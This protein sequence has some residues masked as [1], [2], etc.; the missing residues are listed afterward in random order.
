MK[1]EHNMHVNDNYETTSHS[2]GF[3]LGLL[4]GAAVGAA[5][6]LLLAPKTGAEM[7]RTLADSA[8][9]FRRKAGETY[10]Q[11]S[12]A[13]TD[14][15]D[16]GRRAARKGRERV[17]QAIEDAR[18]AYADETSGPRETGPTRPY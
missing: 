10:G 13:V 11:A 1:E 16:K 9:R 14:L 7:R 3:V 4:C 12:D 17:D 18:D 8:E 5:I 2:S 15:M 6:G